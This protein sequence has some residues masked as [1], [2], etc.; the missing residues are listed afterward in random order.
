VA[1]LTAEQSTLRTRSVIAA[2]LAVVAVIAIIGAI[3]AS[4]L[5]GGRWLAWPRFLPALIW[6]GAAVAGLLVARWLRARNA[7]TLSIASLAG[8]IEREQSLRA[9]SLR[10]ALEVSDSGPLGAH[11]ARD[12]ARR[13]SPT[14][15]APQL[16]Q[17]LV[18]V[19]GIAAGAAVI[20]AALLT[21]S[22][23]TSGDGFAAVVHPIRA[24]RGTLLPA[25]GFDRLPVSVPRGMPLTIRVRAEGRQSIT[26][27]RHAAGE[28]WRDTTLIVDP[29]DGLARLALG[30]VR[31]PV[32]LRVEDGRA[33]AAEAT[34]AV[35]DRGWIG[36]VA[37][38]AQ[39]PAYLGR[40]NETLDA[41]SPIRV[42]RGTRVRVTA[43]L[44]GGV[45]D[46]QLRTQSTGQPETVV[47]VKPVAP[48]VAGTAA[49]E[50]QSG[51]GQPVSTEISLDHDGAWAWRAMSI[52]RANGETLPPELP[53]S[54]LFVV[55]PDKAPEIII[56]S[57]VSD[58]AIGTSGV[59]PVIVRAGD[60]HGIGNVAL[61]IW[62]E[63]A[64]SDS[65]P[66]A[67]SGS[68]ANATGTTNASRRTNDRERI[69]IA[70]PAMPFFE[71]GVTVA[72]DGRDLGPGDR[73][74]VVAIATDD[75]P[76]RQQTSSSEVIL[77]VPTLSEQR[78]MA[79]SLADSLAAR[80]LQMAQQE[81]RL[82]Q[83]TADASRSRDLKGGG[84]GEEQPGGAKTDGSKASMSFQAAEKARQ[85]GREQQQMSA[86]IDSLRQSAKELENRLKSAGALDSALN[87]RMRDIQKML[88]DAMTPEMQKQLEALNKS[89]ERLSGT[90]A[91]QSME[92]LAQQ[93]QQL[94]QQ[95][96]KS[97]EMLKRAALEG[98]M[99]TLRDEAKELA[100]AQK[101]MANQQK[102][103]KDGPSREDA[104][105]LADR[106]RAL[107]DEVDK[108]AKRLEEAGAKPGASKTRAAQPLL[109]Q[110][111]EAMDRA[112]RE[113]LQ[114]AAEQAE[115]NERAGQPGDPKN[116][117]PQPGDKTDPNA[118]PGEQGAADKAAQAAQAL[119]DE[120]DKTAA[121]ARQGDD[122]TA[123]GAASQAG[124]SAER[125]A[126][127]QSQGPQG[128]GQQS[129]GQQPGQQGQPQPGQ[130][131]GQ[132]QGQQGGNSAQRAGEAMDKAAQQLSSAREAQVDAW[133]TELSQ[134]LDQSINE[135]MQLARQQ[136]DLEQRA[137]QSGNPQSMQGEQG[138]LQ[139][140]VQQAAERLEQAGRQSSLLS[141]R[142]QKAMAD[143]QRRVSQATQQMGQ[144]GQPGS[145]EQAQNAMKDATEALNQALSSLVRDRERVNNAQSASGFTEMMEQ[146]K[147]LAQQQGALNGQMQGLN[148]LPGGAQGDAA[149]QQ[150]RVLARQQRDVAKS[151][152]DVSDADQTGR[153]DALAKEAQTLAQQIERS[154]IDPSVAARQQQLYRRLLDAGRFLEQDERDDQG[155][156][157]AKSGSGIPS[158]TGVD[159][160]QSGKAANKFAPPT[161]NELRGLGAEDRRMVIEYF[162]RLNGSTP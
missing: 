151:L 114:N 30:P 15:L 92:Q 141:Q 95:L 103:G 118:K 132:G 122:K 12:V 119:K 37:L 64:A 54:L 63:R 83:N 86:K 104:K 74:H 5:S 94:R 22:A 47:D 60:D 140:G 138:A 21:V 125:K 10:G 18:R 59:V 52:P 76:W 20:G 80:A 17:Q 108:L 159:G 107:Q 50:R 62:R 19:L 113:A 99:S 143:A 105:S 28:P 1:R 65:A 133:K 120:K 146:L 27:S 121:Q 32:M 115:R 49:G 130:Q 158:R 31:A 134:Q 124:N 160:P 73:L 33:P 9:G 40:T 53:D 102:Q 23:R 70:D 153:T 16:G 126:G 156:R 7:A 45:T 128:G 82:Q 48:K 68:G 117:K 87:N 142:S 96:E 111:T 135:T 154:G 81:K 14:T 109:D 131:G 152:T 127:A 147:Q 66:A 148:L 157:E 137:R 25:L 91:Q 4:A 90:E 41:V 26:V 136:A 89:T 24:F 101:Q 79:R 123:A 36:D 35:D 6:I 116:G 39:Y 139:Q 84:R 58:T 85:L 69:E 161:W 106:S 162:R 93:Q 77:R 98:A 75:S 55:V 2:G 88:R 29:S 46:V 38:Y 67:R 61:T 43:V 13:L 71:G 150:A 112:A 145:N 144:A 149:K 8:V 44:R 51:E 78:S 3:G 11:A 42:P 100:N 129:G 57:P 72:L 155:P 34:V 56:A 97:A 110:A